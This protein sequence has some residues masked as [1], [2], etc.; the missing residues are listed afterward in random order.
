MKAFV[1]DQFAPLDPVIN[2]F[3]DC[4]AELPT[5]CLPLNTPVRPSITV[6]DLPVLPFTDQNGVYFGGERCVALTTVMNE[7]GPSASS[8]PTASNT[9][10]PSPTPFTTHSGTSSSSASASAR[11]SALP[12]P[13]NGPALDPKC[14]TF[15]YLNVP[16]YNLGVSVL[17]Y[18]PITPDPTWY[19]INE[20]FD[21][22]YALLPT[23]AGCFGVKLSYNNGDVVV[24][25]ICSV[26]GFDTIDLNVVY[27]FATNRSDTSTD[28][29]QYNMG[30]NVAATLKGGR[31]PY[32]SCEDDAS[33][34]CKRERSWWSDC[35][36]GSIGMGVNIDN[37]VISKAYM[38]EPNKGVDNSHHCLYLVTEDFT[39]TYGSVTLGGDANGVSIKTGI[40]TMIGS[41]NYDVDWHIDPI[42]SYFSVSAIDCDGDAACE[43]SYPTNPAM[44]TAL[45]QM[46]IWDSGGHY[47]SAVTPMYVGDF[48]NTIADDGMG[49]I[50]CTTP[51]RSSQTVMLSVGDALREHAL[52][53]ILFQQ[54]GTFATGY[55]GDVHPL[56]FK[57]DHSY[58]VVSVTGVCGDASVLLE[59]GIPNPCSP[60]DVTFTFSAH[61]LCRSLY[62]FIPGNPMSDDYII[63]AIQA[64]CSAGM[65]IFVALPGGVCNVADEDAAD[66]YVRALTPTL[67]TF[68]AI[69]FT[70]NLYGVSR[71]CNG[72]HDV[73]GPLII[74]GNNAQYLRDYLAD[75]PVN[76]VRYLC[77]GSH[78]T[79]KDWLMVDILQCYASSRFIPSWVDQ[80]PHVPDRDSAIPI[81]RFTADIG[82]NSE[83]TFPQDYNCP[84]SISSYGC[85][86]P[87]EDRCYLGRSVNGAWNQIVDD[88]IIPTQLTDVLPITEFGTGVIYNSDGTPH[89]VQFTA[90]PNKALFK[91]GS[92]IDFSGPY[93]DNQYTSPRVTSV[94]MVHSKTICPLGIEYVRTDGE[95]GTGVGSYAVIGMNY[96]WAG[97]DNPSHSAY[98]TGVSAFS[99]TDPTYALTPESDLT[100]PFGKTYAQLSL[101]FTVLAP[102]PNGMVQI[103]VSPYSIDNSNVKT[104]CPVSK[105]FWITYKTFIPDPVDRYHTVGHVFTE[106][107]CFLGICSIGWP[108]GWSTGTLFAV[109]IVVVLLLMFLCSLPWVIPLCMPLCSLPSPGRAKAV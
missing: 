10:T 66:K 59:L 4:D 2:L 26:P 79:I 40:H 61:P 31:V 32:G 75:S 74:D 23:E 95:I 105:V 70:Y 108:F 57:C 69:A 88:G 107:E 8:P 84:P 37:T 28:G 46:Y 29:A 91:V 7:Y 71:G 1:A 81:H 38:F 89:L 83:A 9:Q 18:E 78:N 34:L 52:P 82:S 68:N 20:D 51:I 73:G 100:V 42:N 93:I 106:S 72:P 102:E 39:R 47:G 49:G 58:K 60:S 67:N 55:D 94:V 44:I 17:E 101:P 64:W 14:G 35:S 77:G 85:V 54:D 97:I 3:M 65:V 56:I 36:S 98:Y 6:G 48:S 109:V 33:V 103:V 50:D 45:T 53:A 22:V 30:I 76:S 19:F 5:I 104:D 41:N 15:D 86:P 96:S 90:T 25:L 63:Y 92:R 99:G 21:S 87:D 13:P 16:V 43:R 24:H 27:G 80:W 11:P 62:K 12:R